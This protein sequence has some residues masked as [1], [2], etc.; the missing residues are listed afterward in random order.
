M[1]S[2]TIGENGEKI[3]MF[4]TYKDL[5]EFNHFKEAT[6]SLINGNVLQSTLSVVFV[7]D[8]VQK[9]QLP[10]SARFKYICK[11]DFNFIGQ[12][13][14]K[15][16][17]QTLKLSYDILLVFDQIEDRYIKMINKL[18]VKQRIISSRTE[19]INFDIR[20]NSNSIKIEQIANFA[21]ETLERIQK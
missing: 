13:K 1:N 10:D 3:I 8:E 2:G 4:Y 19:G 20:L 9:S 17:R 16:L 21:K 11:K 7:E 18:D 6:E 14:D 5:R 15:E 12:L